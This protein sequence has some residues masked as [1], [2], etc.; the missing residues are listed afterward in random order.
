MCPPS[1]INKK[2]AMVR[3]HSS[4][5]VTNPSGSESG[6]AVP[7]PIRKKERGGLCSQCSDTANLCC[8]YICWVQ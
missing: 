4:A 6:G 2:R 1:Y 3:D 7:F 5:T 8:M